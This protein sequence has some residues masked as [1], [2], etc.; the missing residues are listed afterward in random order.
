MVTDYLERSRRR[1]LRKWCAAV[2]LKHN[3]FAVYSPSF[4][5]KKGQKDYLAGNGSQHRF[6]LIK[7][8]ANL[9]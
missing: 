3:R 6:R 4:Q 1:F 2:V 9:C 7:F 8:L 5:P